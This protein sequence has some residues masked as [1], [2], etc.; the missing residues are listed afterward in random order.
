M[1]VFS[2]C[3]GVGRLTAV[4]LAIGKV[5]QE[6]SHKFQVSQAIMC[7]FLKKEGVRELTQH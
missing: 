7:L 4:I 5:R 2:K 3:L 1:R 6:S